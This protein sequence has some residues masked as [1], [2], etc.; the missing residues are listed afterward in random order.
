LR[1]ASAIDADTEKALIIKRRAI[2]RRVD[3]CASYAGVNGAGI[4]V[5][6]TD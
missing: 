6:A 2:N 3:A 5:I 4:T 1:F